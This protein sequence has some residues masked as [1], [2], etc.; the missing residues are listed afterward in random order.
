MELYSYRVEVWEP[1]GDANASGAPADVVGFGVEATDGHIGKV[2][3]A[4]IEPGSSCLVVDTGFW[5][6]GK[7]RMI[8]AAL[9]ERIDRDEEKVYVR[10][11]KEQVRDA[12]DY[13]ARRHESD[14]A[15]YHQEVGDYF[16]SRV[17]KA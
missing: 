4:S 10:L 5:I 9:V 13:D 16:G 15:G 3:E 6:F 14:E 11:T 2:D 8:P 12:P 1:L 7:Q 17:G